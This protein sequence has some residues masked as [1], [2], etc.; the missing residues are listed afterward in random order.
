LTIR[1][2]IWFTEK[3]GIER[4]GG[5]M[6]SQTRLEKK[7]KPETGVNLRALLKELF[8]S[9]KL[10]VLSTHQGGQPYANLVAFASTADFK[11]LLFATSRTTRKF[12]NLTADPRVALLV[13]NRSNREADFEKALVVSAT[14]RAGEV[15]LGKRTQLLKIY[16]GKHPHLKEFVLSSDCALVKV[17]VDHYEVVSQF[18]KVRR[19]PM[20]ASS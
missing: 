7:A 15:D 18:Q 1:R 12:A 8:T 9:Q 10:A 13:D 17:T 11:H 3:A 6:M 4:K 2:R 14:G 20:Q 19:F 16:L 5:R